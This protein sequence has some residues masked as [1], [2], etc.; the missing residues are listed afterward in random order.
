MFGSSKTFEG[1]E[2]RDVEWRERVEALAVEAEIAALREAPAKLA[3]YRADHKKD[4]A[5]YRFDCRRHGDFLAVFVE[6]AGEKGAG[7]INLGRTSQFR[8][9]KGRAPDNGGTLR[10]ELEAEKE[11]GAPERAY[12]IV[13]SDVYGSIKAPLP[14]TRYAVR[15]AREWPHRRAMVAEG[16]ESADPRLMLWSEKPRVFHTTPNYPREA[17]DDRIEFCGLNIRIHAP[18]GK[19]QAV[20]DRIHAEIAK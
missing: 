20:L 9:V 7:T 17:R 13:Q 11:P 6:R 8:L 1:A 16:E 2:P 3:G 19:G 12:A 15:P 14:G 10:Y 18:A 5:S 4:A